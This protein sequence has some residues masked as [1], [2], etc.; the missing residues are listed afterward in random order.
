[1]VVKCCL[2]VFGCGYFE[3][4]LGYVFV[5]L[6]VSFMYCMYSWVFL[7]VGFVLGNSLRIGGGGKI[8]FYIVNWIKNKNS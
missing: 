1:M 6:N 3:S 4:C 2:V 8:V 7:F 5:M